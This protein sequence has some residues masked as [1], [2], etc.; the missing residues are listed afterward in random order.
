MVSV[1]FVRRDERKQASPD[2]GRQARRAKAACLGKGAAKGDRRGREVEGEQE[3]EERLRRAMAEG[4]DLVSSSFF[5]LLLLLLL[6]YELVNAVRVRLGGE[7]GQKCQK[8]RSI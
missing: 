2:R 4:K 1:A 7:D 5:S 6:H 3:E 8:W